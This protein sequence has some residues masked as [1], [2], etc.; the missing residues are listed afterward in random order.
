[1]ASV[2]LGMSKPSN[3]R[4]S[5]SFSKSINGFDSPIQSGNCDKAQHP[6]SDI[7]KWK[8]RTSNF[9]DSDNTKRA[10]VMDVFIVTS[11]LMQPITLKPSLILISAESKVS[12]DRKLCIPVIPIG[13][14]C[15]HLCG[16]MM[17]MLAIN[18]F[19]VQLQLKKL[20]E[21]NGNIPINMFCWC[22]SANKNPNFEAKNIAT[23]KSHR[24]RDIAKTFWPCS[25]PTNLYVT[26]SCL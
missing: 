21:M 17:Y 19:P 3:F 9:V 11:R 13:L 7:M 25:V 5:L 23:V 4:D 24:P 8:T 2:A 15:P 26:V 16:Y 20:L 14:V 18:G 1:M 10:N 6:I 22:K 12:L